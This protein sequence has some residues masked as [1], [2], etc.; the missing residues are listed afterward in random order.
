MGTCV[1]SQV[2][3]DPFIAKNTATATIANCYGANLLQKFVPSTVIPV[4]PV[5]SQGATNLSAKGNG[6]KHTI[7]DGGDM[8]TP[9]LEEPLPVPPISAPTLKSS[10]IS[11]QEILQQRDAGIG[12]GP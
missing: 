6:A 7:I 12:L 8:E 2:V 9:W 4:K 11:C 10:L 1:P 5:L 3:T